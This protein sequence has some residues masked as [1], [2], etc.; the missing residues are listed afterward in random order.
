MFFWAKKQKNQTLEFSYN[1]IHSKNVKFTEVIDH[2]LNSQG[3]IINHGEQNL[4]VLYQEEVISADIG[5][6]LPILGPNPNSGIHLK[7]GFGFISQNK[8]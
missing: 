4:F 5:K 1:F 3:W 8:N 7:A 2:L 6:I